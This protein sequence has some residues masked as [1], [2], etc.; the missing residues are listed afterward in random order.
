VSEGKGNDVS[1]Q[2]FF[3]DEEP[4]KDK[5][6]AGKPAQPA[7]K[8]TGAPA[9]AA[10]APAAAATPL[11]EQSVSMAVAG[12]IGVIGILIGVILGFLLGGMNGA[13]VNTTASPTVEPLNTGTGTAPVL[14]PEQQSGGLPAG[15]PNVSGAASGST[16]ATPTK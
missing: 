10:S 2:D 11:F 9:P 5:P 13:A 8:S 16:A 4:A 6:A 1:D 14:T 12:M 7:R 15:H 3:F